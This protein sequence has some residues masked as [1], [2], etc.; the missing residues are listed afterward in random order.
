M[1]IPQ[2]IFFLFTLV[3]L[4]ACKDTTDEQG[5]PINLWISGTIK[6]AEGMM[7]YVE[8]PSEDGMISLFSGK[9]GFLG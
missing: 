4:A 6:G 9:V 1:R 2:V 3:L 8:A 5:N 7:V